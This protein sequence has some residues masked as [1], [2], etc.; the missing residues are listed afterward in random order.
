MAAR[1]AAIGIAFSFYARSYEVGAT[2]FSKD[3]FGA[4]A[5]LLTVFRNTMESPASS[6]GAKGY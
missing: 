4:W 6:F 1:G 5:F 3:D 2:R